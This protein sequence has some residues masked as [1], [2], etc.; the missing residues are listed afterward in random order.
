MSGDQ[1][2]I[3]GAS[4]F[5]GEAPHATAQLLQF[6][7][8]DVLVFDY[9]AEITMSIMARARLKDPALGY[10]TDFV[11]GAMAGNLAEIA[12]KGVKV[13]S[14]AGG[15]NP[16]ACAE[17]LRKAIAESGLD[18][19][20]AVV[21]GDDL[22]ARVAEFSDRREMFAGTPFPDAAKIASVNAYLGAFPVAAA[23]DAGADIVITGRCAD[24]ALALAACIHRFGWHKDD[25]DKLAAGSLAGH[26]LECGPQS[27][28][29]NF[30]DWEQA[31]DL[32][33][34]GYPVAAIGADGRFEIT[35]P[36]GTSGI[37]SRASVG[38]QMLY[39][40]GD[41]QAYILPD[42]ICDF[43]NVALEQAGPDRVSVSGAR[44]RAPTGRLK[45]SATFLDGYRA[46][47]VFQFNG[48]NARDKAKAFVEAGLKRAEA[49]LKALGAPGYSETA[50]ELFGGAPEGHDGEEICVKAAVRHADARAVGLF[51]KE[52]T[53]CALATPPGLHFF[54]GAGRPKPS[55][56]VR[57][58]SFLIEAGA[59]P[60]NL[61]ID[62]ADIGYA[63]TAPAPHDDVLPERPAIPDPAAETDLVTCRLEDLAWA[64][65]GDKGDDANIGVMAR[66]PEY[67]PWIWRAVTEETVA[68]VFASYLEGKVERFFMPG[69][70]GMN[71]VMH[72]V[73][74]GGGVASL[75]ND[76]QGK[77]FAQT[78]L[79]LPVEIP[80]ALADNA[81]TGE[82]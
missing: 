27:T 55:P 21:E 62:G 70:H 34:I 45:V 58:F 78:L 22:M 75:R 80:A 60:V 10:A 59:V 53:G 64:R 54:T 3:G 56:V 79:A 18:L 11:T 40:I 5:W 6:P 1:L 81:A 12:K 46:G 82:R 37:V 15:V 23:L 49:R 16:A 30:T 52:I 26:L 31:G 65:S 19:K 50:I 4:G 14:N 35:K 9:L 2:I 29:G 41:P 63:D 43:S 20:V 25:H 76:A 17:A 7:G 44:G 36:D 74:G 47:F 72:N 33:D 38:E 39:E 67:L 8:I 71:I 32:A 77:A 68:N 69:I 51:L 57:L 61:S 28:G 73:L 48:R 24:S 13:L 66:R 42:V